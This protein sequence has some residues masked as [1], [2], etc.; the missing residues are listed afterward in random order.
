MSVRVCLAAN[1]VGYPQGG[2]HRWPYLNWALGLRAAGCRVVWLESL[3]ED[4]SLDEVRAAID[5][6]LADL[7]PFGLSGEVTFLSP[8]SGPAGQ[9]EVPH[10]EAAL[11][12]D[13]LLNLRYALPADALGRFARTALLDIDPGLTQLW[14]SRGDIVPGP[15]DLY[16]TVGENVGTEYARF[17][18]CGVRWLYTPP[19][20]ALDAWPAAPVSAGR[21]TTVSHWWPAPDEDWI[22]FEGKWIEN[23]KREGFLDLL[24]V[25]ARAEP[26][27]E[28]ALGGIADDPEELSSLRARGWWV[29]DA[30]EVAG[31]ASRYREYVQRSRGELSGAKPSTVL[32]Q[33][34]WISDRSVCYLASGKPVVVRHT[35]PSRFLRDGEGIFRFRDAG[36]AAASIA[37]VE[38]DYE[39][40]CARAR[41]L[42][43]K[44]FDATNLAT[45]LLERAL[46]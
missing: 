42:A 18:D 28:L 1:T 26:E 3:P 32:L 17:P 36:E 9:I 25:P 46:A 6:L 5:A 34:G 7:R 24:G 35:G 38:S 40:H 21:Y 16:F 4:Q 31:T 19:C 27:L 44:H 14:M 41:E 33:P 2:G 43:E 15:H 13:L 30:W 23:S 37:A 29:S 39:R 12:A 10:L 22:N 45:S 8:R 11:D 20:V